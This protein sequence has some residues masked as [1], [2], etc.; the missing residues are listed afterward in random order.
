MR[1]VVSADQERMHEKS[2]KSGECWPK[3]RMHEKKD[4]H[5]LARIT[6]QVGHD[7]VGAGWGL[8]GGAFN[9]YTSLSHAR[10]AGKLLGSHE[11][12]IELNEISTLNARL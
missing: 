3:A 4:H 8:L 10:F 7:F 11:Y 2:E 12:A 9:F 1:K 6:L 5:A